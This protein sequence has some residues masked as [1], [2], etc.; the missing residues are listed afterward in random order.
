MDPATYQEILRFGE[1]V[2]SSLSC[3]TVQKRMLPDF[4]RLTGGDMA[5][6]CLLD[7]RSR[8]TLVSVLSV[9]PTLLYEIGEVSGP[10]ECP[11]VRRANAVRFPVYDTMLFSD[12]RTYASTSQGAALVRY[13]FE[14]C[15]SAPLIHNGRLIGVVSIGREAGRPPYT[16]REA[17]I[18]SHLSRFATIALANAEAHEATA[19]ATAKTE[20]RGPSVVETIRFS[21]AQRAAVRMAHRNVSAEVRD[22][23]SARELQVF[24]LL[25]DGLTNAEIG[26]ELGIAL[27]TV[28]QHVR[29]IYE[30]LGARSRV[31]AVRMSAPAAAA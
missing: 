5:G 28:K 11:L 14:H 20:D 25:V 29:H 2:C 24:E 19:T 18:A 7:H 8:F 30:K 31:E 16:M 4:V 3:E 23:L 17:Q 12:G 10:T 27:N 6:V 9:S 21:E 13:G 1:T 22:A 26:H 15:L